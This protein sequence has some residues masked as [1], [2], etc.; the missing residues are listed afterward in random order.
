MSY[1]EPGRFERP[2]GIAGRTYDPLVNPEYFDGVLGRR[3]LAFLID[4]TIVTVPVILVS[5]LILVFGILTLGLGWMLFWL[6]SPATILWAVLYFG[7]TLGG[8]ASATLGM[9]A[10][11]LEM[12]TIYGAPMS[13]LIAATHVVLFWISVSALTPFVL[14]VAFF[15]ARRRLVHDFLLG[16]VVVNAEPRADRLRTAWRGR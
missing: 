16:T 11:G 2:F 15:N 4:L 8:P 13:F 9:R 12:H 3:I 1:T 7:L 6:L 14:L 10:V 5:F